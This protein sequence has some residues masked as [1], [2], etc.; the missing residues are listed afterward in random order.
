MEKA[1]RAL[2]RLRRLPPDHPAITNELAEVKANHDFEM[3]IGKASYIDCFRG[4]MAKRQLT[5]M[6]LQALQQLT[7]I[8]FVGSPPLFSS[9]LLSRVSILPG[10]EG[11]G[12]SQR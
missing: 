4:K 1:G 6:G 5:G 10:G 11:G 12:G 7:G 2:G 8:N 9:P 3:S